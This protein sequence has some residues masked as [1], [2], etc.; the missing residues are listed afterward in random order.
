MIVTSPTKDD[1]DLVYEFL[2]KGNTLTKFQALEDLGIR[3]LPQRIYDLKHLGK[4]IYD[5]FICVISRGQRIRV[6]EYSLTPFN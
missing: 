6:K 3:S 4:V 5:R 1:N 2:E